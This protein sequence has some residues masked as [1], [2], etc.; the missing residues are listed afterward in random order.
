MV[1]PP[2]LRGLGALLSNPAKHPTPSGGKFRRL[3]AIDLRL[4][5]G[6]LRTVKEGLEPFKLFRHERAPEFDC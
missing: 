2:H 1:G 6:R 4:P 3:T 5:F